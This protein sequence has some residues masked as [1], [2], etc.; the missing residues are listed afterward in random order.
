MPENFRSA[1]IGGIVGAVATALVGGGVAALTYGTNAATGFFANLIAG[2]TLDHLQVRLREGGTNNGS[3]F[4]AKC[5]ADEIVVGGSCIIMADNG[6]LQNA[7]TT[8]DGYGCTYSRRADPA[9]K[10]R[11]FA[12]CLGRR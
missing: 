5:E 4:S 8:S 11:I 1:L 9:V 12:A 3:D 10:A 7:G 6:V 2:A